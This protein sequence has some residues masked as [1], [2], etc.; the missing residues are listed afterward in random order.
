MRPLVFGSFPVER[1]TK[2]GERLRRD[3]RRR[4]PAVCTKCK[5]EEKKP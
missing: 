3:Y 1:C 2:C 4:G 5:K